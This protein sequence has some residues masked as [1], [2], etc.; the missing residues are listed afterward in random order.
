MESEMPN[1]TATTSQA[2]S[3]ILDRHT[4]PITEA[5]TLGVTEAL[6]GLSEA[7][8]A[9][10]TCF[11]CHTDYEPRIPRF[12]TYRQATISDVRSLILSPV[13]I[14]E[15]HAVPVTA[16]DRYDTTR[17]VSA[18]VHICPTCFD[19]TMAALTTAL[20]TNTDRCTAC[21]SHLSRED[22]YANGALAAFPAAFHGF[23][24]NGR[25]LVVTSVNGVE[26]RPFERM[27]GSNYCTECV[28]TR[29]VC[30]GCRNVTPISQR[31]QSDSVD[32]AACNECY[33]PDRNAQALCVSCFDTRPHSSHEGHASRR[34]FAQRASIA[35]ALRATVHAGE[36]VR[37]T[38]TMGVEIEM[39]SEDGMPRMQEIFAADARSAFPLISDIGTDGSIESGYASVGYEMRGLP[40]GG[41]AFEAFATE[42]PQALNRG[43]F[44]GNLS[45][46][47][48]VHNDAREMTPSQ[49][50][51]FGA[52]LASVQAL[53][54]GI[55]DSERWAEYDTYGAH[56]AKPVSD[57]G[58]L[59]MISRIG[60]NNG[61]VRSV[62]GDRYLTVNLDSFESHTTVEVRAFSHDAIHHPAFVHVGAFMSA[63]GTIVANNDHSEV[64]ATIS[65]EPHM[66]RFTFESLCEFLVSRNLLSRSS[67]AIL[68]SAYSTG[69]NTLMDA[70]S[71]S[72]EGTMEGATDYRWCDDC[73]TNR[74]HTADYDGDYCCDR[75]GNVNN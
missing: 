22:Y 31:M 68:V 21:Y 51:G 28:S 5:Y 4:S 33:A 42:I 30:E 73:D 44:C 32:C 20:E 17:N 74:D 15:F 10:P 16:I 47:V 12:D 54:L 40:I 13:E 69:Q 50:Y 27:R 34:D 6:Q 14:P 41:K 23:R 58:I 65:N 62:N 7:L 35:Q 72:E 45:T 43:G 61:Y 2:L 59:A 9:F 38:R 60:A 63:V 11:A 25:R 64:L 53:Y 48:H 67:V 57:A 37:S 24:H 46:G 8:S 49:A 19:S 18:V 29:F 75:C 36:I 1:N 26:F 39:T 70:L 56:Y 3:R 52:I 71:N 66:N 55:S